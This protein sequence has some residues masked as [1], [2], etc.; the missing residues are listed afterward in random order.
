[1]KSQ[2]PAYH[3]Q[4]VVICVALAAMLLLGVS[5]LPLTASARSDL[6]P[7]TP[8]DVGLAYVSLPEFSRV[9][10]LDTAAHTY[11]GSVDM[12]A[13]GCSYPYQVAM[14]PGEDYVFVACSSS[15]AVINTS[16]NVVVQNIVLPG[17]VYDIT[18][19][20]GGS[21]ALVTVPDVYTVF[22]INTTTFAVVHTIAIAN[23]PERLAAH[24]YLARAYVTTGW[25]VLRVIDTNTFSVVDT[26]NL[27][28]NSYDVIVSPAGQ[29]VFVSNQNYPGEL[30]VIDANTNTLLTTIPAPNS[31]YHLSI[32]PV[33]QKVFGGAGYHGIH[34][35]DVP[36]L[37]YETTISA[38]AEAYNPV[39]NCAGTELYVG[40]GYGSN[41]PVIDV[42]NYSVITNIPLGGYYYP[43]GIAICPDFAMSGVGLLPPAQSNDGALG[44]TVVHELTL[45]NASDISDSYDISLGVYGWDTVL[46]ASQVGPLQPGEYVTFTVSVTVPVSA[47]WY[48]EDSVTIYATSVTSPTIYTDTA[49]VT[50]QAFSPAVITVSPNTLSSTQYFGDITTQTFGISNGNG[51]TLTFQIKESNTTNSI[52][53]LADRGANNV[54]VLG[55]G[56]SES[57]IVPFLIG[58][59]YNVTMGPLGYQYDGTNPS[60]TSFDAVLLLDGVTYGTDMPLGGQTALRDY[61][62]NGGGLVVTEW[63]AFEIS[64]GRYSVLSDLQ[65]L[66]RSTG[67]QGSEDYTVAS[68]NHPVTAGLPP[69]FTVPYH[70]FNVGQA[71]NGGSPVVTGSISGDAVVAAEIESGRVV[72]LATAASYFGYNPWNMDMQQLLVNSISWVAGY[73][74]DVPWIHQ[75]PVSGTV[76]TDSMT[77]VQ[78]VFDAN[79][80]QPGMY[81]ANLLVESND[82][83]S[84]TVTL[85]VSMTVQPTANVGWVEGTITDAGTGLPLQAT[86]IAQGQ[87]YTIT[88]DAGTGHYQLWLDAG[89]YTLQV[90]ANGYVTETQSINIVAQQ[91]VTQDFD[92]VLNVPVI[93]VTHEDMAVAQDVGQ[94]TS[95]VLTITN[96]GPAL[97]AFDILKVATGYTPLV[98]VRDRLNLA[99]P[100]TAVTTSLAPGPLANM[101]SAVHLGGNPVLIIQDSYPWGYDSIQQILNNNGIAYDQVDSSYMATIDLS[102]YELVIIPSEQ[103]WD[104]YNAWDANIGRFETYVEAGGALWLSGTTQGRM[105]LM[106]GGVINQ[107]GPDSYNDVLLPDHP[108]VA[109]VSGQIF[110]SSASHNYFTNLSPGSQVVAQSMGYGQATLVDYGMG[111]GRIMLTGQTLEIAW[112]SNWDAAPIL[113]NSLLDMYVWEPGDVSWLVVVPISGTVAGYSSEVGEVIFDAAGL[114]PGA[115][116]ANVIINSNDPVNGRVTIPVTMTVS[117]APGMGRVMGTVTDLWTGDPLM[118]QVQLVGVYTDTADP[119]YSIWAD[120]GSYTLVA[121]ASG[122]MTGT[123]NVV[124][125]ANG[126]VVQ[127]IALEPAQPR[128]EDMPADLVITAVPGHLIPH[129]FTL[130]NTGPLPLDYTWHE[131]APNLHTP[132]AP[133]DLSGKVIMY[134]L[135]HGQ[136]SQ[137]NYSTLVTAINNA[138]GLLTVNYAFPITAGILNNVDVLWIDCCGYTNWTFAE[139]QVVNAWMEAGGAVLVHSED[140]PAAA[141]V[142]GI[143]NITYECCQYSYG[144]TTDILPH[145]T[146]VG[147]SAIY[148][149]YSYYALNYTPAANAVVRDTNGYAQAVA[150]E[151]NGGKMVVIDSSLFDNYR[152][153]FADNMLFAMNVM[154]WLAAPAYGDVPWLSVSPLSGAIAGHG[155]QEM[156]V[157]VDTTGLAIGIHEAVLAMEHN[158]PAYAS[159][160]LLPVT[161]QVV[162]QTAAVTLTPLTTNGSGLP[163]APVTYTLTVQNTGNGPDTFAISVNGDWTATPSIVTTNE[164]MPGQSQQFTVVVQVPASAAVGSM[165]DTAVTATSQFNNTISQTVTLTTTATS[166]TVH[167]YLPVILKP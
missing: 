86:I 101:P 122:Y 15:V 147:V 115:Y 95:R 51:I 14:S 36:T 107:Y 23:P 40:G 162:Q 150:Q 94:A 140:Y 82:P 46:S 104:F 78:V 59:G 120:A 103:S 6:T 156:T 70:G 106:P 30:H 141:D 132:N 84:P 50:T 124:I 9:A 81:T 61:V 90:S 76:A 79:N 34:V 71:V 68:S 55:D 13:A 33:G 116:T 73:G 130:A 137:S 21:Y 52:F 146:T 80:I 92:L 128:L 69:N 20:Q 77:T 149:D 114:Q 66:A 143:Y 164:L 160:I 63:F 2:N 60:P 167:I 53:T 96:A 22:V 48:E 85:P 98:Y 131:I 62:T 125:P 133:V 129:T 58:A 166:S 12:A 100:E 163:G 27:G 138:G 118:A 110:G 31:L 28:S 105:P 10:L 165:E 135:A 64:E 45:V 97:L 47:D 8:F 65:I 87:P 126:V 38:V 112:W 127:D 161:V 72:Q 136:N 74:G 32:T 41:V 102:V 35:F 159:P 83:F 93:E 43:A 16:T 26:I 42:G 139:L 88:S 91:G 123:Y 158:D 5:L 39:V 56:G 24:P 54:L 134:D 121:S 144:T 4:I 117:P 18:F 113:E 108:W 89:S 3:R 153:N 145:P 151:Q 67:M 19:V 25:G 37:S 1:M 57:V 7:A 99:L 155:A 154:N 152:I 44:E 11:V 142:A 111:A 75:I 119:D 17:T 29:L 148:L 109:G 157:M 49:V